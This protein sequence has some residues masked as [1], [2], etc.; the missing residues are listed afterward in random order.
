MEAFPESEEKQFIRDHIYANDIIPLRQELDRPLVYFGLPSPRMKDVDQWNGALG[1]VIAVER[2]EAKVRGIYRRASRLRIRKSLI[3]LEMDVS[4]VTNLLSLDK[5]L[6]SAEISELPSHTQTKLA[7]IR[8]IPLHVINLDYYGGFLYPSNDGS[9]K[10]SESLGH[11]SNH[12]ER[13]REPFL[14]VLTFQIRDTGASHYDKFISNTLDAMEKSGGIRSPEVEPYFTDENFSDVSMHLRRMKFSVPVFVLKTFFE[15]YDV[16]VNSIYKYKRF[17]S[18]S[19]RLNPRP[20]SGAL[21]RW[22]PVEDINRIISEDVYTLSVGEE[23]E[24]IK[25]PIPAPEF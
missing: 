22:P 23:G 19:I 16:E 21:G 25:D 10:H 18:F 4:E 5:S 1:K 13:F 7:T 6:F 8:D 9:D 14:L 15:S 12:Q 2:D 20:E 17:V 11:I 3:L 24:I